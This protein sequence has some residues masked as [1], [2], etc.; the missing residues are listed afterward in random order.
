MSKIICLDK[1]DCTTRLVT[2]I[3]PSIIN[4]PNS[5]IQPA[6]FF[7]PIGEGRKGE[8]GH[9]IKGYFKK[10]YK[11][12]PLVTII[13]VVFNGE[14]HLEETIQ[15]VI[16]QTYNNI[17]YIIIDGGSTD[18]TLDIIKKY[19]K[20]IDYWVSESDRGIANAWNKG[21]SLATGDGVLF[22]NAGDVYT[23]N[24][25]ALFAA[26]FRQDKI[27][28]AAANLVT[29]DGRVRGIFKQRPWKLNHGMHVPHNWCIVPIWFYQTL[30]GYPEYKYSMD[31]AW[32]HKYYKKYGNDA[33]I[34][35]DHTLGNYLLGGVSDNHYSEGFKNNARIVISNGGSRVLAW[36]ICWAY[37][38]KHRL[39]QYIAKA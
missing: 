19:E 27:T 17:E 13:T 22:L 33:F 21:L 11:D 16:N 9:R 15:S 30:G 36:S 8:G 31:F 18:G 5:K 2:T 32:F 23:P 25:I 3:N 26:N 35:L 28:C 37:I 1:N 39:F 29:A 12:K 14:K 38:L 24:A 20:G 10:S 34:V 6:S 7:L 4:S